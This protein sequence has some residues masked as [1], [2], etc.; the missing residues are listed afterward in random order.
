MLLVKSNGGSSIAV[1]PK[2]ERH[3]VEYL[4]EDDRVSFVCNA[5]YS[6]NSQLEKICKLLIDQVSLADEIERKQEDLTKISK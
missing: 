5:D 6:S 2:G 1:Y 3:H 4:L